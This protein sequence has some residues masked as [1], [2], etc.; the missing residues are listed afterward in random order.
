MTRTARS[1]RRALLAA[2]LLYGGAAQAQ[3]GA[4]SSP[5]TV[6]VPTLPLVRYTMPNGLTVLLSEDHSA[7]VVALTV[8]YHVGSKNEKPGRTGF[9]HLFEHMMFE[10]SENVG[11]GEHRRMIQAMGGTFNGSTTEDR[12]NYFETVPSNQLETAIWMEADRMATLLTRVNQERLDAEREIVKNERR[13]RVDN[14]PFGVADEVTGAALF[15]ATNPYSWPVIGSMAD[16]S[17]ASL[18]DVRE[19]FRTY[20]SPNNATIA[21]SG[22]IDIAKTRE[23]LDRWFGPIPRGPA[24]ERPRVA[25][26]RLAAEKRLV[27]EDSRARLPQIQFTWPTVGRRSADRYALSAAASVLTLDRT[28]RLRKLLVYD[29]Q[30]ATGVFAFNNASEDAGYFQISVQPRPNASLTE[31]EAVVDSVVAALGTAP[32]SADEVQRVKNFAAVGTVTGL[33]SRLAR[34]EQ[35]AAGLVFDGDPLSYRASIARQ[36]AVT[37]ADVQRV[38]RQYLGAGRVVLSMV[39]AGKLDLVSRPQLPYTNVT[40]A[41]AAAP[42]TTARGTDR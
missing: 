17:A 35:L 12:T 32:L 37:P 26:T 6:D 3:A 39:P 14:Q 11:T 1:A 38:A 18:E 24:I 41:A 22:D 20:Y 4:R 21:I 29:R 16:L 5:P 7:P 23:M 9:A 30:L 42:A 8:W 28:S 15:P 33:Q 31:I 27:L 34:A 40:P 2:C 19:F 36:Q 13:L 25:P 10:G